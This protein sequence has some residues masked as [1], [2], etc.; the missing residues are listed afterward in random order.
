VTVSLTSSDTSEGTVSPAS[1]T[2]TPA[3]WRPKP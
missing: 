1:V 2:F 3:N